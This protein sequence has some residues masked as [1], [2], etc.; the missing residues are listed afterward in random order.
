M[1]LVVTRPT[2]QQRAENHPSWRA[3][4]RVPSHPCQGHVVCAAQSLPEQLCSVHCRGGRGEWCLLGTYAPTSNPLH[5]SCA[6]YHSDPPHLPHV[7]VA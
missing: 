3:L 1:Q 4:S 7:D 5:V 6:V 2:K